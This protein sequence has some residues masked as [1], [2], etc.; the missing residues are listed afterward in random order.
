LQQQY[1]VPDQAIVALV[2]QTHSIP[3]VH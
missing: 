2:V 3:I 1:C